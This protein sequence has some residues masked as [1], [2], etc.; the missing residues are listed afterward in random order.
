[1][2]QLIIA[3]TIR[4][5]K[6]VI[7]AL[8]PEVQDWVSRRE[9]P[10]QLTLQQLA[11]TLGELKALQGSQITIPLDRNIRSLEISAELLSRCRNNAVQQLTR[12]RDLCLSQRRTLEA[13]QTGDYHQEVE[14]VLLDELNWRHEAQKKQLSRLQVACSQ[15]DAEL[16][17][18]K[19]HIHSRREMLEMSRF[20]L[21]ALP[22]PNAKAIGDPL[23]HPTPRS[24]SQSLSQSDKLSTNELPNKAST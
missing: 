13:F 16:V 14:K 1:M 23:L 21:R 15:L 3:P 10:F 24:N 5:T 22:A 7:Q 2:P 6:D 12:L 18:T 4:R 20:A 11:K 17:K 9:Q 19:D 8:P